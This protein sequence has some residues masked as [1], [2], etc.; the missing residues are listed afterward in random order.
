MQAVDHR[1]LLFQGGTQTAMANRRK[2]F[3][4][5]FLFPHLRNGEMDPDLA[6]ASA[7]VSQHTCSRARVQAIPHSEWMLL[8]G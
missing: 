1:A 6:Q 2:L 4:N 8:P 3:N 7:E 5:L